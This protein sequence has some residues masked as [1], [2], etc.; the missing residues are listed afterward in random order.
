MLLLNYGLRYNNVILPCEYHSE[1]AYY[2]LCVIFEA[3]NS[4]HTHTHTPTW[5]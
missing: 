2:H 1:N 3:L 5:V 4:L